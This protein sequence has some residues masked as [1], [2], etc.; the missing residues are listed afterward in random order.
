MSSPRL[1]DAPSCSTGQHPAA[2]EQ[3]AT[4]TTPATSESGDQG[5]EKEEGGPSPKI[6]S[7]LTVG[8]EYMLRC[9]YYRPDL[10]VDDHCKDAW[11]LSKNNYWREHIWKYHAFSMRCHSCPTNWRRYT[12]QE[13]AE[14]RESH[15][16]KE[17][18]RLPER[19]E[20]KRF[21]CMSRETEEKWE[22]LK[23]Q[24]PK[25]PDWNSLKSKFGLQRARCELEIRLLTKERPLGLSA[26]TEGN[27]ARRAAKKNESNSSSSP[28]K[29]HG[30]GRPDPSSEG[31]RGRLK[32]KR[33]MSNVAI[34]EKIPRQKLDVPTA[35]Q[36]D[37]IPAYS[38]DMPTTAEVKEITTQDLGPAGG[39][40]RSLDGASDVAKTKNPRPGDGAAV[41]AESGSLETKQELGEAFDDTAA[42]EETSNTS[43]NDV[44]PAVSFEPGEILHGIQGGPSQEVHIQD[45]E[46]GDD[47]HLNPTPDIAFDEVPD[48]ICFETSSPNL[49]SS[50]VPHDGLEDSY[51]EILKALTPT[52]TSGPTA[53]TD[54][55]N[56]YRPGTEYDVERGPNTFFGYQ[57]SSPSRDTADS[58]SHLAASGN[59]VVDAN[60]RIIDRKILAEGRE[61][62]WLDVHLGFSP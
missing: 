34:P 43:A 7:N 61:Q 13:A 37:T 9:P 26:A 49:L 32:R 16:C 47:I 42:P 51:F 4:R 12:K 25:D 58:P 53:N 22:R 48:E 46:D 18:G 52:M 56:V 36:A 62:E 17:E 50:E 60:T 29:T 23:K 8:T 19:A 24:Y 15:S 14:H 40:D 39:A 33:S 59:K 55:T 3:R 28:A 38:P 44:F 1:T 6:Q 5:V 35:S 27:G 20:G 31:I 11:P 21:L 30:K 41:N 57:P 10:G 2:Q 45:H 54:S